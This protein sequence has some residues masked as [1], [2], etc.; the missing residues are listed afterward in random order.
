MLS[1]IVTLDSGTNHSA[2]Q[3]YALRCGP[4]GGTMPGPDAACGALADYVKH[5]SD[6]ARMCTGFIPRIP[7]AVVT[8]RFAGHRLHLQ[9]TPGSW[10][11]VS[12]ALMRDY[13]ILSTF[14]CTTLVFRYSNQHA[15]SKGIAPPRCLRDRG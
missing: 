7:R 8:G 1:V 3:R 11:G 2:P 5:R 12:D 6:P 10:C 13:W 4:A 15:Y 9:I 14:P